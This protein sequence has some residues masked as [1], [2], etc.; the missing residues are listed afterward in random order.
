VKV[1]VAVQKN[2]KIKYK[3]KVLEMWR[4]EKE[5]EFKVK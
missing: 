2:N 5:R 4:Q 3:L 1:G